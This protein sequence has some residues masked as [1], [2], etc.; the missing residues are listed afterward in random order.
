VT[1]DAD[2][3]VAAVELWF[4]CRSCKRLSPLDAIEPHAKAHCFRCGERRALS[5]AYYRAALSQAHGVADLVAYA[6]ENEGVEIPPEH[7]DLGVTEWTTDA[8][9]GRAALLACVEPGEDASAIEGGDHFVRVGFTTPRCPKCGNFGVHWEGR[10]GEISIRC[11]ECGTAKYV[12]TSAWSI[13]KNA[14]A[15]VTPAH[16]VDVRHAPARS[17]RR[18]TVS[19]CPTCG[20]ALAAEAS[21][22]QCSYC[23]TTTHVA[24]AQSLAEH[25]PAVRMTIVFVGASK[26]RERAVEKALR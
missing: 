16:R 23:A 15:I 22:A 3:L 8:P 9:F 20:A 2:A 21:V 14:A 11:D 19:V 1:T 7:V 24:P 4:S 13:Y 25:P 12:A 26:M 5:P 6:E 18:A 10:K 17:D